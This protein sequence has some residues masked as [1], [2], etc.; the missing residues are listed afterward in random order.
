MVEVGTYILE[1]RKPVEGQ[2]IPRQVKPCLL[3]HQ[4]GRW[5]PVSHLDGDLSCL[6]GR[7]MWGFSVTS[8]NTVGAKQHPPQVTCFAQQMNSGELLLRS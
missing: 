3:G 2:S 1:Y 4:T 7:N 8:V 5:H 6:F